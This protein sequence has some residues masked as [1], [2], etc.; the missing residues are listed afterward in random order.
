MGK[1]VIDSL[2][3]EASDE[4]MAEVVDQVST[5][6]RGSDGGGWMNIETEDA[7]NVVW[8]SPA[9]EVRLEFDDQPPALEE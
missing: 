9:S 7:H 6:F 8:V 4:E 5:I 3:V 1:I 2:A